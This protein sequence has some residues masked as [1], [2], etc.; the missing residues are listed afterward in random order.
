MTTARPALAALVCVAACASLQGGGFPAAGLGEAFS[1]RVGASQQVDGDRLRVGFEAVVADSRCPRG[2]RCVAAGEARVRIWLADGRGR[3]T[4][5]LETP[6]APTASFR[7]YTVELLQLE[8][9]PTLDREI[10]PGD[11]SVTLVVR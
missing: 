9:Y 8:P 7:S 3:E 11:Y 5:E 2:A 6:A 10:A 1:L 4:R